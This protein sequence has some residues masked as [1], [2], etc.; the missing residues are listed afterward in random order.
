MLNILK[1][2]VGSKEKK[3]AKIFSPYI[4]KVNNEFVKLSGL[5]NDELRAKTIEFKKRIKDY[6]K[7]TEDEILALE[8]SVEDNPEMDFHTKDATFSKVDK[9]KKKVDEQIEEVLAQLLPEEIE[10]EN[11]KYQVTG[12]G[13][14]KFYSYS[15][16]M[17][18]SFL[19]LLYTDFG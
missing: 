4:D 8:K 15:E 12:N 19:Q 9:L 13:H 7:S 18:S 2:I 14:R 17:Y 3:D 1:K 11:S 16:R 6:T 10:F 5:S